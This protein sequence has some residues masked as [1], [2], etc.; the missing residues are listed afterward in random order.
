MKPKN[1]NEE[2]DMHPVSQMMTYGKFYE[3]KINQSFVA[4]EAIIQ[5]ERRQI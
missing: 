5:M 2:E 1:Q 3:D 4:R